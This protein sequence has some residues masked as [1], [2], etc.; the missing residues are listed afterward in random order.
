LPEPEK[1]LAPGEFA[2]PPGEL[3]GEGLVTLP[4]ADGQFRTV[5]DAGKVIGHG[6]DEVELKRLTPEEKARRRFIRNV[7]MAVLCLGLLG[8]VSWLMSR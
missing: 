4:T 8:F 2:P 1:K 6:D 5:R 3:P 7:I